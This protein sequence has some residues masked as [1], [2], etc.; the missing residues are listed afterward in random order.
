MEKG[1][2]NRVMQEK[3]PVFKNKY[4]ARHLTEKTSLS[5]P[6]GMYQRNK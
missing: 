3:E 5:D 1:Q 4:D 6:C 2:T